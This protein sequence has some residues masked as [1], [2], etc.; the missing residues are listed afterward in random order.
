MPPGFSL[1]TI[2]VV[3]LYTRIHHSDRIEAV[4]TFLERSSNG[5]NCTTFICEA[6]D[7]VLKHNAFQFGDHWYEQQDGIAMG[8]PVAP[9]FANLFLTLWEERMIY[10]TNNPYI[11]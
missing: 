7:F 9:T 2:D 6:L 3:S 1:A 10:S 8:T 11:R 4:R 5:E